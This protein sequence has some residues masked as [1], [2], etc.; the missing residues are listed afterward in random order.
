MKLF[1]RTLITVFFTFSVMGS[2]TLL[3][4]PSLSSNGTQ[5]TSV[6]QGAGTLVELQIPTKK[7]VSIFLNRLLSEIRVSKSA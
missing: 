4:G 6:L 3:N 1:A 2:A 7:P 5:L